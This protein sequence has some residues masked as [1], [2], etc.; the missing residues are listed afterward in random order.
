MKVGTWNARALYQKGKLENAKLEMTRLDIDIFGMCEIRWTG[1]GCFKTGDYIM[2]YSS[3]TS[4]ERGVGILLNQ[5][6]Q[7]S[8]IG[9]WPTT[10][11]VYAPTSISY[12]EEV[13]QFYNN[14]DDCLKQC[15]SKELTIVI[16]EFN[17][18]VVVKKHAKIIDGNDLGSRNER[19]SNSLNVTNKTINSF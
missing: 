18:K 1:T 15:N 10:D 6:T 16:G 2:Y 11:R 8:V 19:V 17:T 12:D 4:H 7:K 9:F 13:K 3:G 5:Q 14:I